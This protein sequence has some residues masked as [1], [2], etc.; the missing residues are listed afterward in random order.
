MKHL[1]QTKTDIASIYLSDA[2]PWV[3][4]Y[5][6]GKDSTAVVRLVFEA[7]MELPQEKRLKPVF[8]VSSDTLVETP[9][10]VNLIK[11]TLASMHD[12]AEGLKL[13][14]NVAKPVVPRLD[15]TFWVNLL[16]K[17]YP[18]PT[19]QFRWCTERM[20]IDP[21]SE[22][23]TEKVAAFGEVVVVLGSR[24]EESSSRAQV[25]RKHRIQGSRLA[26]HTTLPNAYVF[27]PIDQWSADDVWEYLFSGPAPWGGDHQALFDLYK[28]SN[29]GECPLVIDS[30]TPSCGNSRFGCWVCTVVTKDRAMDGL[31]ETG[32]TWLI[33]LQQ[34]RNQLYETTLPDQKKNYRSARRR[35]GS[36]TVVLKQDKPGKLG[37]PGKPVEEKHVLGPYR[38]EVRKKLLKQLLENQKLVNE[39][40][41]GEAYEL[42]T[43]DELEQIRVEWRQDPNEPDWD[44]SVPRIFDEVMGASQARQWQGTDDF[45]F[46]AEE[47]N[48]IRTLCAEHG[49]APQL[50]MKLMEVEVSYE[51]YA[52]RSNVQVEI[53]E[54]LARD[55]GADEELVKSVGEKKQ[56]LYAADQEEQT[57]A[58]KYAR[59]TQELSDAA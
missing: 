51:G 34:F 38:L 19:R 5:S 10:V 33:P 35:D 43:H 53:K 23:I 36:V 1:E 27:T 50:F 22:F 24:L 45:I 32:H 26:R 30:S 6:G 57:A 3:I 44:D 11:D 14:L 12:A 59:L 2:R 52:R 18:A 7:L 28:D 58:Q 39:N 13:P 31:I 46:G 21:V 9:L 55:W 16:G 8:V 42:I 47:A 49:I 40:N 54:L 29:A 41:P 48:L 56:R 20:K 37:E 15:Q 4:G 25:M 17:G